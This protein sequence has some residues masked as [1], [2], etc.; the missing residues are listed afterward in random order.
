VEKADRRE[1]IREKEDHE[2]M[3]SR[4]AQADV[5][6]IEEHRKEESRGTRNT[7]RRITGK[8]DHREG[9][10]ASTELHGGE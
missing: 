3:R 7:G 4:H 8:D 1:R 2:E 10:I 5:D 6:G 9:R